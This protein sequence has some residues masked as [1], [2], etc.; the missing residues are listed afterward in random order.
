MDVR[1]PNCSP[2]GN[3]IAGERHW[4]KHLLHPFLQSKAAVPTGLER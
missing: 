2:R 4:G 3:A 1:G